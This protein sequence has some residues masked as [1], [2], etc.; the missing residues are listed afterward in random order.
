M[1]SLDLKG[2]L[3][4]GCHRIGYSDEQAECPVT[5]VLGV[6]HRIKRRWEDA[7]ET[8]LGVLDGFGV[9]DGVAVL[10]RKDVPVFQMDSGLKPA[11]AFDITK[12]CKPEED[13][14]TTM[15]PHRSHHCAGS[16]GGWLEVLSPDTKSWT[17][18]GISCY[19]CVFPIG[20]DLSPTEIDGTLA[21][22]P[23]DFIPHSLF[24]CVSQQSQAC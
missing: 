8:I 14:G 7:R 16:F 12:Y 21:R 5:I 11:R 4:I 2:V 1:D 9:L 10:V 17:P 13:L 23:C 24:S 19:H 15:N 3:V 22:S 6:D 20:T 18:L